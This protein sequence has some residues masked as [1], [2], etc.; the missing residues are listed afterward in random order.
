MGQVI[1]LCDGGELFDLVAESGGLAEDR[2]KELFCDVLY[3]VSYC[4]RCDP[5]RLGQ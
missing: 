5:R 2:A 1:E 3:A 4:H